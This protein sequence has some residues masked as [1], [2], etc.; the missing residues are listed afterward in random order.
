[1]PISQASTRQLI[2][3]R[4]VTCHGFR[5]D[6]GLWDIEGHIVDV[7]TYTFNTS[8][9]GDIAPGDYIHEMFMRVT[10]TDNFKVV[11]VEAEILKSPFA[12]CGTVAGRFRQLVGL[13][14]GAGW[15]RAI[16]EQLGGVRGCTHLVELLGPIATT[17]FQTIY[18]VLAREQ[19]ER[20]RDRPAGASGEASGERPALLDVCHVFDTN[21][22]YVREH[23][24]NHYTGATGG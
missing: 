21:G 5:R 1:M 22:A 9:R 4:R 12:V 24:P 13:T 19:A 3:T 6:D 2:H 11:D 23:W 18:P 14:I 7:K 10:V 15:N 16:K 20:T 8:C 17:A